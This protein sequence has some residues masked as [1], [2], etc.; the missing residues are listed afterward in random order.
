MSMNGLWVVMVEADA[1]VGVE[2]VEDEVAVAAVV[3]GEVAAGEEG[4]EGGDTDVYV[5]PK[6]LAST[7][8][9][10]YT[11]F[12]CLLGRAPIIIDVSFQHP[13]QPTLPTKSLFQD[14]SEDPVDVFPRLPDYIPKV[15]LFSSLVPL[16]LVRWWCPFG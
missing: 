15:P 12:R 3:V 2:E 10:K 1:V 5:A 9:W 8:E 7:N 13:F 16:V 11:H 14:G 6:R 4:L